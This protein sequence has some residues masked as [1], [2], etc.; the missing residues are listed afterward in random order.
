MITIRKQATIYDIAKLANTSATTVSRVLSNSDYPVSIE[1]SK[2]IK[3]AAK[4]LN[5]VPNMVGRQLKKKDSMTIGVI[6]PTISNPFYSDVVLGIEEVARKNGYNVLLCNYRQDPELERNYLQTL[7]EAQVRGVVISSITA[8]SSLLND[9]Q[10]RGLN[11]VT[12]DQAIEDAQAYQIGFDYRQ[13]GYLAT[14]HLIDKGHKKIAFVTAPLDRPSRQGTYLGYLD[15]LQEGQL[16]HDE[17]WVQGFRLSEGKFYGNA[18]EFENGKNLVKHLLELD[19]RP[20]AIFCINDM[21]AFGVLNELNNRGI[22]V[23]EEMSVV[24][25]DNIEM[26]KMVTPA[27]TT[28][29]HPKYEMG[30]FAGNMLVDLLN[31]DTSS[32]KQ[33]T[34]SPKLIERNSVC[35]IR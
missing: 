15:A 13:S 25:L 19:E 29:E 8:Q 12:I 14:K 10:N 6:V 30:K 2:R 3:K 5:Y 9:Y 4:E 23:P 34:L 16:E 7:F 17:R 1:L 20:T 26:A 11:I 35:D 28:I 32:I 33:I 27:L 31:G 24:G 21:T 18:F 22:R